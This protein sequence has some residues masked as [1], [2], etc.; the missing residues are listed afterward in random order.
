MGLLNVEHKTAI[1]SMT[2]IANDMLKNPYYLYNDKKAAIVDFFN[3]N[4]NK[5]TLDDAA[6]IPYSNLGPNCPIVF[7]LIHDFYIYGIDRIMLNLENGDYGLE[8]GEITGEALILPNTIQPYPGS[9]FR[10]SYLKKKYL[11]RINSVTPD[12]LQDGANMWKLEYKLDQLDDAALLPLVENEYVFAVCNVGNKFNTIIKKNKYDVALQL[13]D[14]SVYL[15]KFY[16]SMFYNDKVQTFTVLH[17]DIDPEGCAG[18]VQKYFYGPY[19]IEFI[20]RNKVLYADGTEY[21]YI[22]HQLECPRDFNMNYS[23][24][25]WK[26]LEDM[27]KDNFVACNKTSEAIYIDNPMSIFQ[28]RYEDYF[29]LTYRNRAKESIATILRDD[30]SDN[31]MTGKLFIDDNMKKYNILVK[32]FNEMELEVDDIVPFDSLQ[33][34]DSFEEEYYF[35]IPMVIYC[36][37]Y[38]I[39]SLI[40]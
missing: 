38:Y 17:L 37:D 35:L 8:S 22:T 36:L 16:K 28:T 13:D 27:D 21:L 11:F 23:K 19:M 26:I 1:K 18:Q 30:I 24:S 9:Y 15:K 31:I 7:D 3:I 32:Y 20:I 12:T 25:I 4:P 29:T 2:N 14:L 39:K 33:Y 34:V 40:S 5:S 6:K 10:I